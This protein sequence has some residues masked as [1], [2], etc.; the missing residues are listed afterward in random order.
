MTQSVLVNYI[1]IWNVYFGHVWFSPT[2]SGAFLFHLSISCYTVYTY[3]TLFPALLLQKKPGGNLKSKHAHMPLHALGNIN[4][5]T[6]KQNITWFFI[7]KNL[8]VCL[9]LIWLRQQTGWS[10][11]FAQVRR[12]DSCASVKVSVST[13]DEQTVSCT[14]CKMP[15][16]QVELS[17]T[18]IFLCNACRFLIVV[19]TRRATT[20]LGHVTSTLHVHRECEL[21]NAQI[22]PKTTLQFFISQIV[23]SR[24]TT[25]MRWE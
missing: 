7:Y 10:L 4:I 2:C 3:M 25:R 24:L 12:P 8:F 5:N 17:V 18:G 16:T 15:T 1:C 22:K 9:K 14:V 23:L 20:M 21:K 6:E 19:L 13:E 11:Y